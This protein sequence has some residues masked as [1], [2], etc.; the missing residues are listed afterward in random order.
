MIEKNM[1]VHQGDQSTQQRSKQDS[2]HGKPTPGPWGISHVS[3]SILVN[4]PSGAFITSLAA[5]PDVYNGPQ[6]K[7]TRNAEANARLISAAPE[8]LE[9]LKALVQGTLEW[10]DGSDEIDVT[11]L[12]KAKAAIAKAEGQ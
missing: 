9:A 8:L 10:N 1:G 5:D 7:E 2:Q 11:L 12:W 3:H 6:W 4:A